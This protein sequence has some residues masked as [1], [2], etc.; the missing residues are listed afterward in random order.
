M[1][2]PANVC[3]IEYPPE[4]K[5][6]SSARMP[7]GHTLREE[8]PSGIELKRWKVFNESELTGIWFYDETSKKVKNGIM[9]LWAMIFPGSFAIKD[10]KYLCE[11]ID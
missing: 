8:L 2:A 10:Y 5:P 9:S 6:M 11:N 7:S 3:S 4:M 1:T